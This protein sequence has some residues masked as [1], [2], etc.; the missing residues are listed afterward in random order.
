MAKC[1][2]EHTEQQPVEYVCHKC[3]CKMITVNSGKF[4]GECQKLHK[5]D[6]IKC[7]GCEHMLTGSAYCVLV[8]RTMEKEQKNG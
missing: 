7:L 3:G 2:R 8:T 5:R 6:Y 1:N 4:A